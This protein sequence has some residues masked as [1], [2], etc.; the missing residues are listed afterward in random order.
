VLKPG[1][2]IDN[3]TLCDL[4]AVANSGG[5]RRSL[6]RNHLVIVADWTKR[7]VQ[8]RW[9]GDVLHYTG[10]GKGDQRME[11]QNRNL[12]RSAVSGEALHLFEVHEP[13]RYVYRGR[14]ERAGEPYQEQQRAPDSGPRTVWM[15]PLR[16]IAAEAAYDHP[17]AASAAKP[18]NVHLPAG[19][20]AVVRAPVDA[21]KLRAVN[22]ALDQL[23]A[24]G[25]DVV[26]R[27]DVD[28]ARHQRAL[29]RWHD[30]IMAYMRRAARQMVS[31]LRDRRR[32][33]HGQWAFAPDEVEIDDH[34]NE[35]RVRQVLDVLGFGD[36]F[37]R[38]RREAYD[39]VPQPEP[40]A[41]VVDDDD[42]PMSDADVAEIRAAAGRLI[43]R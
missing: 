43:R 26:D 8:N 42:A 11:K 16:L 6:A 39:A 3:Q 25:V 27:R 34:A 22:A 23:K 41:A 1:E 14:A 24:L 30:R 20:Y 29:G 15:F 7:G 35:D 36:Q 21:D 32:R 9:E 4:F 37:D 18:T 10:Q 40:P 38:L 31:D 5:M 17:V 33:E 12:A 2:I 13:G 19:V 28:D